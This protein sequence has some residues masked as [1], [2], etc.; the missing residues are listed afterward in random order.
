MWCPQVG[1][2]KSLFK[3]PFQAAPKVLC[4]VC[5]KAVYAVEE[6]RVN[7]VVY[8]KA[9]FRCHHCNKVVSPTAY[10]Q[11]QGVIYCKPHF[12]ALFKT[13]GKYSDLAAGAPVVSRGTTSAV[14]EDKDSGEVQSGPKLRRVA[15]GKVDLF[16]AIKMSRD[17]QIDEIL[18]AEGLQVLFVSHPRDGTPLEFAYATGRLEIARKLLER[19]KTV[20]P[21]E[22]LLPSRKAEQ[23]QETPLAMSEE[24]EAVAVNE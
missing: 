19:I 8:H 23:V 16:S 2:A 18:E 21:D 3:M 9:C 24:V 1:C 22:A 14:V 5:D 7:E 20:I 10:T 4:K 12:I 11:F 17:A 6:V 13:R 15:G